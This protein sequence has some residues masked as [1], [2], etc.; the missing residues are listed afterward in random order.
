MPPAQTE[1]PTRQRV[2]NSLHVQT[3]QQIR[4]LAHS[5]PLVR[6]E[7]PTRP[8]VINVLQ[9]QAGMDPAASLRLILGARRAHGAVALVAVALGLM[10]PGVLVR[11]RLYAQGSAPKVELGPAMPI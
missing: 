5:F 4:P 3:A 6:M 1:R 7:R 8:P 10:A 11:L 2:H 9:G